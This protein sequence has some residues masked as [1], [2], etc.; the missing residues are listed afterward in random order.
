MLR[1]CSCLSLWCVHVGMLRVC[2]CLNSWCVHVG[3]LRICSCLNLWCVHVG[4]LRICSCLNLWCVHVGMLRICSC[5]NLWCVHV[6]MLRI[7]SCLNSWCVQVAKDLKIW[8]KK[9]WD[10]F[11]D[12]RSRSGNPFLRWLRSQEMRPPNPPIKPG[13]LDFRVSSHLLLMA[14]LIYS[15]LQIIPMKNPHEKSHYISFYPIFGA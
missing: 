6:G 9:F 7:C 14:N 5:L 11:W 8:V 10:H 12:T 15:Q 2:S 13:P 4:M 3:M 1:I